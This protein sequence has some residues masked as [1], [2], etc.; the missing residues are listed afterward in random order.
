MG[1]Q[2]V[3]WSCKRDSYDCYVLRY[4]QLG[5]DWSKVQAGYFAYGDGVDYAN[6]R[7][8]S[9]VLVFTIDSR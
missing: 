7:H 6:I 1:K 9:V 5:P 3:S 2:A 4:F 8:S